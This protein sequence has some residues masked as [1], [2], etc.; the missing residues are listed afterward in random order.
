MN[1]YRINI[2][3]DTELN[4]GCCKTSPNTRLP[5]HKQGERFLRGP[6]PW[7]WLCSAARQKGRAFH[8]AIALWFLAGLT[9]RRTIPLSNKVLKAFGVDRFA[10]SRALKTLEKANLIS[11]ER[12]AGRNPIVT[13]LEFDNS[14]KESCQEI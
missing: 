11:V 2:S 13:I 6:I 14:G 4:S 8:V 7:L 1:K 5:R 10:K 12:H 9:S 3:T